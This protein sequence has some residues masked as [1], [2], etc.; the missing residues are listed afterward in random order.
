MANRK[1]LNGS[2]IKNQKWRVNIW[3]RKGENKNTV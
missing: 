1:L 3:R 2:E